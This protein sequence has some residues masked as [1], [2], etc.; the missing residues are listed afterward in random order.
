M[1]AS[2][3]NPP[4]LPSTSE[5]ST[6]P[7]HTQLTLIR[8]TDT[9]PPHHAHFD[10]PERPPTPGQNVP[11]VDIEHM[12]CDDDPRE[13]SDMKKRVVLMMMTIAVVCLISSKPVLIER[14][15]FDWYLART[16]NSAEYI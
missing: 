2:D 4:F 13:W 1:S 7:Q 11:I 10:I 3:P 9:H 16:L 12:P 6:Q 8:S 15:N 14:A 5:P